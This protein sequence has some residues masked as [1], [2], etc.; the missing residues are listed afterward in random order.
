M[1]N[2]K[3]IK[4]YLSHNSE[5]SPVIMHT[6]VPFHKQNNMVWLSVLL[7]EFVLFVFLSGCV[8]SNT[9]YTIKPE[10]FEVSPDV[11]A[12]EMTRE[13]TMPLHGTMLVSYP[14]S[15]EDGRYWRVGVTEGLYVTG[16]RYVPSPADIP[17]EVSGTRE[18]MV[19]AIAPGEN[20]FI[21]TLRPR[22]NSWNQEIV[23]LKI[24]VLITEESPESGNI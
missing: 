7:L 10:A 5:R 24:D 16:D 4:R 20:T 8:Q 12:D 19:K 14:W 9:G 15:P 22:G 21:G 6:R 3:Y 2:Q 17:V 13:I 11:Y 1:P 23:Q 18:W